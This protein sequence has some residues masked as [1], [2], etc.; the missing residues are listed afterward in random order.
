MPGDP[1]SDPDFMAASPSDQMRYLSSTDSD[2]AAASPQ[3]QL[4]YL[5]HIRGLSPVSG[6][7]LPQPTMETSG[8]GTATGPGVGSGSKVPRAIQNAPDWVGNAIA[9]GTA[10]GVGALAG[11][12][13]LAAAKS[14]IGPIA[15]RHPVATAML[16]SEAIG[17]A[18]KI[19]YVG[20]FVPPYSE[21]IPFL[22][23]EGKGAVAAPAETAEGAAAPAT[24]AAGTPVPVGKTP[25]LKGDP[26]NGPR[27][28]VM[29][30]L[31]ASSNIAK[32]GYHPESQTAV[33]EFK[34][35]KVYEYRG[36]PQAV[37]DNFKN[38]ES[39]GSFHAQNIKGRYETNYLGAS[40][41]M[42]AG[43][44]AKQ[45]LMNQSGALAG[46]P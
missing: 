46:Q 32:A 24:E 29:E 43:A 25:A 42:S 28:P 38:A 16:A 27:S 22:L 13:A 35:G 36:V 45:A 8:I 19:P 30:T 1:T 17:Q 18:R 5:T 2:F 4:G 21:M 41:P 23:G 39:Q 20:K 7:Q 9:A 40:K 11:A 6:P 14:A 26:Y 3:E 31:D 44:K 10:G 37:Y 15:A 34:N 33:M 12:P